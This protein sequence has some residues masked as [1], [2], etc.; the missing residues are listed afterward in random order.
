MVINAHMLTDIQLKTRIGRDKE[1]TVSQLVDAIKKYELYCTRRMLDYILNNPDEINGWGRKD[2]PFPNSMY[3]LDTIVYG[4][5]LHDSEWGIAK[6]EID[7]ELGNLNFR[8]N[9][10][11]IIEKDS[12]CTAMKW[13]RGYRVRSYYNGVQYIGLPEEMRKRG[14]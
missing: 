12:C 10:D 8:A 1:H 9:L 4:C 2:E 13:L 7:L 5:Y 11:K 14:F 6:S 3:C